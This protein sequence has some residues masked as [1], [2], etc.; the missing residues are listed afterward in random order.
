MKTFLLLL[1]AALTL[2]AADRPP[3]V[4]IIFCD[5][6]GYADIGPFGQKGFATPNLDRMAVEGR[7]LTNFHVSSA[8]CSASRSALITGCYHSR[9]GIH[10]AL[11]PGAKVALQPAEMTIAEVLKQR[12][13]ATGMS[14]KWHL[15]D[16]PEWM[17]LAQGFDEYLGLPYS[18]DMW[19]HHPQAKPGAYPPLPMYEGEKVII[20]AMT[21]EDQN[22]L[23]TR[24][25]ERAV[26]FIERN[27]DRPFFF[28]LAHSMPHVPLHVSDKFAGK[29]GA[30]LFGDAI[31]EIDWSVGQVLDAL[32]RAGVDDNTLVIFTSDNGPW[33]SYGDHAG[34]A[35][36]L[37]E[38]KGTSWD[39]GTRVP[40][41]VRWPGKIP[42]G[43]KTDTIAM[44]IDL[45]P[46]L[47]ALTGAKLPERKIDGIDVWPILSGAP[48][49][50]N[51]HAAYAT[52]YARNELQSVTDGQWKLVFPHTYRSAVGMP[53]ATGGI[54]SLYKPAKVEKP[55]LYDLTAD[56]GETTD[57]AA[58]HPEVVAK[59]SK[60]ADQ[61][62]GELGDTLT[63][64]NGSEV[65]PDATLA[66]KN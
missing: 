23:T 24:Y 50:K 46:T 49:A 47:A 44:T 33:L 34:S 2:H 8:V 13:Y 45:L 40:C 18:N 35:G 6:L 39:G 36:P 58:E 17:P 42:A 16:R 31:Q 54:P 52:W 28:Y 12:G 1:L 59:L 7:C 38:G 61:M 62:R 32:K 30:G 27:K 15:G 19:P 53:R 20:P 3:N 41:V 37:R 55:A 26:A 57:R 51:P 48:D 5:D 22:Q 56:V 66:G 9:V 43:S 64:A 25:T 21:H 14:G 29:S 4:V 10:G 60:F 11:G 65:R 63:G